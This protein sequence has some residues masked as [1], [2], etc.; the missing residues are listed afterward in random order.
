MTKRYHVTT[1]TGIEGR[2]GVQASGRA[3]S[4][5]VLAASTVRNR[6]TVLRRWAN[7][8]YDVYRDDGN[9]DVLRVITDVHYVAGVP[10]VTIL[11]IRPVA[12][13]VAV[14]R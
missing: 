5:S 11:R 3:E 7:G 8:T 9:V 1:I 14:I 12:S 10:N 6:I 13:G 2:N 4:R